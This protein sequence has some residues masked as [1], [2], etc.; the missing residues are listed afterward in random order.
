MPTNSYPHYASICTPS[1]GGEYVTE[2][3]SGRQ[4][5]FV[6]ALTRTT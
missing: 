2:G 5:S 6:C 4:P 1:N 3:M